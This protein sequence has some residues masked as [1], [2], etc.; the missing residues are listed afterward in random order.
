MTDLMKID[1]ISIEAAPTL[2]Y[3]NWCIVV[4]VG[5]QKYPLIY[6]NKPKVISEKSFNE[7]MEKIEISGL[8]GLEFELQKVEAKAPI[9]VAKK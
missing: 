2:S 1:R 7:A 4:Y 3:K 5:R 6:L 8:D 9:R